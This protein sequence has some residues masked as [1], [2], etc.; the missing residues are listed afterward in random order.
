MIHYYLYMPYYRGQYLYLVNMINSIY[1]SYSSKDTGPLILGIIFVVR[2]L[3]DTS[4]IE[5]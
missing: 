5:D 4:Y 3:L 2:P 1:T